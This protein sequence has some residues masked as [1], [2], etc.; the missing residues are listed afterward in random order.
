[1]RPVLP[2]FKARTA[3]PSST[4]RL[5]G[6]ALYQ[7][8][9]GAAL[10]AL[11]FL[12]PLSLHASIEIGFPFNRSY[13]LEEVGVSRGVQLGFDPIGRLAAIDRNKYVVLNDSTWINLLEADQVSRSY[14]SSTVDRSGTIYYGSLSSWGTLQPGSNGLLK[15]I[16]VRPEN[17]PRWVNSTSFSH[18][19]TFREGIFFAGINGLVYWDRI[20]GSQRF[21]EAP[22]LVQLFQLGSKPYLSSHSLGICE[23]DIETETLRPIDLGLSARTT[24]LDA[25]DIGEGYAAVSTTDHQ[26]ALFDGQKLLPWANELGSQQSTQISNL[27]RLP[28]GDLAVAIDNRGLFIL[29]PAGECK[30]AF[31][32]LE[33]HLINHLA[34]REAGVLWVVTESEIQKIL[35]SD[36]VTL[37]DQRSGVTVSWPQLIEHKD[38]SPLIVS[39]GALYAIDSGNHGL[40]PRFRRLPNLPDSGVLAAI[41]LAD[42]L[43]VGNRDGVYRKTYDGF[44]KVLANIEVNRLL[45][46]GPDRC[47][48]I[49]RAKIA[50]LEWNGSRWIE[51]APSVPGVG[52]PYICIATDYAAWIEL[53]NDRSA[54]V[55]LVDGS[56]Q[57]QVFESYPWS[58]PSWV[59]IGVV[60]GI[61][62]LVGDGD[63][64][65]FYDDSRAAFTES[66][67]LEQLIAEAPTPIFRPIQDASGTI[68]AAHDYG[69]Y[70]IEKR[71]GR[72]HFDS[73]SYRTIRAHVP[74]LQRTGTHDIW[75]TNGSTL[76][77]VTQRR[78]SRTPPPHQPLLVSITDTQTNKILYSVF[79][80]VPPPDSFPFSLNDLEFQFFGGSYSSA[81]SL[82]YEFELASGATNWTIRSTESTLELS[83]LSED[84]YRLSAQLSDSARR[85]ISEPLLANFV[86]I[87]PWFRTRLAYACYW[88]ISAVAI[89]SLALIVATRSKRRHAYL[90]TLV[91]ERT[92]ELRSTL[93]KLNEKERKAAI[94]SERNRLASEIHDSVQQGLSGL[95]L[96]LEATLKLPELVKS[97][98][99]RLD[100]AKN[101]VSFTRHEVQQAIWGL[102]SPLLENSDLASALQKMVELLHSGS[103]SIEFHSSGVRRKLAP[104]TQHHLLRIAQE[105]VTNAIKHAH[106]QQI[107]MQL[108]FDDETVSLQ[109]RDDGVGFQPDEVL[110]HRIGHFGM[111]GMK[112]RAAKVKGRLQILSEPGQGSEVRITCPLSET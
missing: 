45:E 65:R 96:Q 5:R 101:M 112:G 23:I 19:M 89:L 7:L 106:C 74:I 38:D 79:G 68:W 43:L 57:A 51:A 82:F 72:Y 90:E 87:P 84:T 59:H 99:S 17:A 35:Y 49:G 39:H 12:F 88:A 92:E 27:L 73:D 61:V 9:A 55:T 13:S 1:M 78:A 15:R 64:H 63:G 40:S 107:L 67:E 76:F 103:P 28:D 86:I 25:V 108:V 3:L 46:I 47:L 85:P 41:H 36:P 100:V 30:Q 42:Q 81:S 109:V 66:P 21:I 31:T 4:K 44:E 50:A 110:T 6:K 37:V 104:S 18:L 26:L 11:L 111:R 70:A 60:D 54:R 80:S 29:T 102:E 91:N 105:A 14:T 16:S 95:A 34:A 93:E 20:S 24:F 22:D 71:N 10:A 52:F 94:L 62:V 32:T 77:H 98:R 33:Y 56:I 69:I 48:A 58:E 97:V 83:N 53:G 2:Q 8:F 75:V